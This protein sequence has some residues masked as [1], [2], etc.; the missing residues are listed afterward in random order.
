METTLTDNGRNSI[1]LG[2]FRG[3]ENDK[4]RQGR[5]HQ[6][7]ISSQWFG[8][9]SN[10]LWKTKATGPFPNILQVYLQWLLV[11]YQQ[12]I[13]SFPFFFWAKCSHLRY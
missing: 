11:T 9:I 12:L 5:S 10:T 7:D 4:E 6:N 2:E 13:Q 1:L 3:I 8:V